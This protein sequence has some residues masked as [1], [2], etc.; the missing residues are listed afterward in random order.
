M[1]TLALFTQKGGSGKTTLAVHLAVAA[2]ESGQQVAL[3]DTDPQRS[4]TMWGRARAGQPPVVATAIAGTL[5]RV[6]EAA[7]HDGITLLVVDSPPH[8]TPD[9][10]QIARIADA[11][12]IPCRPSAFDLA[13]VGNAVDIVR[14]AGVP[15]ALVLNACPSRAPEI[16][17]AREALARFGLPVAPL[18]ISE[19]RAFAR[20]VATGR[21][22][23]EFDPHG[24]AAEEIRGLWAWIEA[25]L[26]NHQPRAQARA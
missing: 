13:A 15:A 22:V 4:A 1:R 23:T 18:E 3:A 26:L 12:L 2:G 25:E 8:T 10:P 17:E 20:A 14:A 7:R 16:A 11:V 19:R 24:K 6:L 9:A 21:A 5:P